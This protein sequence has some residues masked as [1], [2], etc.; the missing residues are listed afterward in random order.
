MQLTKNMP[1]E[2]STIVLLPILNA[3]ASR[4]NTIYSVIKFANTE[5]KN[6]GQQTLFITFHQP[7]YQKAFEIIQF[8][9]R[10]DDDPKIIIRLGGF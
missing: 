5:T 3:P 8:R 7:L 1:C 10:S 2:I 4:L 6:Y 9:Q